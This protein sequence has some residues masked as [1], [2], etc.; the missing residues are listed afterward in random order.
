MAD[1]AC[2]DPVSRAS[3]DLQDLNF[4]TDILKR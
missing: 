2:S 4:N 1:A 3:C